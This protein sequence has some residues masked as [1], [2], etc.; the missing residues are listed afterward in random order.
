[1][2][3]QLLFLSLSTILNYCIGMTGAAAIPNTES[4]E[5]QV[6]WI[7]NYSLNK[8]L[9]SGRTNSYRPVIGDCE[10]TNK[11]KWEIPVTGNGFIKSLDQDL[12]LNVKNTKRGTL[13]MGECDD[14]AIFDNI[15]DSYNRQSITFSN[16]KNLCLGLLSEDDK[17]NRL[18]MN[19]FMGDCKN[20]NKARWE[21]PVNGNGFIKSLDQGLCLNVNNT[22]KGTLIMGECNANA[23]FDNINDS[24]NRESITFSKDKNLCLGLLSED[25]KNNRLNMNACKEH[26][27]DQYWI[28]TPYFPL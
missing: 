21:I 4:N 2:K 27:M 22:K 9:I 8:C 23:I 6:V 12:C 11:A 5:T 20:T 10:N 18:N 17:D 13:L 14:N 26:K 28:F 24:Y 16:D 3:S 15:K 19:A 25:D 1:M 7:Y